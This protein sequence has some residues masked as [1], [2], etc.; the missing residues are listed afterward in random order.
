MKTYIL[1]ILRAHPSGEEVVI[2]QEIRQRRG[3]NRRQWP[4]KRVVRH[5]KVLADT[6]RHCT[7]PSNEKEKGIKCRFKNKAYHN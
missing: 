7:G 5:V 2:G 3:R 4:R 1:I 6:H